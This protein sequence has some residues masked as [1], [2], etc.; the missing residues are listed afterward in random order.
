MQTWQCLKFCENLTWNEGLWVMPYCFII[1]K[2]KVLGLSIWQDWQPYL[3]SG[4]NIG[5]ETLVNNCGNIQQIWTVKQESFWQGVN[6]ACFAVLYWKVHLV[7]WLWL[8]LEHDSIL[9]TFTTGSWRAICAKTIPWYWFFLVIF[10]YLYLFMALLIT[11][12]LFG[13]CLR[14][15]FCA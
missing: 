13:Y 10:C 12:R 8:M 15:M 9:F 2:W 4:N 7:Q 11:D 5:I 14:L 6:V 1:W 3:N